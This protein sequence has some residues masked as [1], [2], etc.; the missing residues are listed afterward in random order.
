LKSET[1]HWKASASWRIIH[2][3]LEP[4]VVTKAVGLLPEI[5]YLPGESKIHMGECRSAGYWCAVYR[6]EYPSRPTDLFIWAENFASERKTILQ[7]MLDEGCLMN[8]YIAVHTNVMSTGFDLV[9][10]PA[11]WELGIAIGI[12]FFSR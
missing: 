12:E 11:I 10:L 5:S 7:K 4:S 6:V 8:V 2:P 9:P 3:N 1:P